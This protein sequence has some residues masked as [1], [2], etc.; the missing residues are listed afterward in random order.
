MATPKVLELAWS[1]EEEVVAPLAG[2]TDPRQTEAG[3]EAQTPWS[4]FW[5][6]VGSQRS[7]LPAGMAAGKSE[8]I[9]ARDQL[10]G[11]SRTTDY[12]RTSWN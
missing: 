12:S 4:R 3:T 6:L 10:L 7:T 8:N 1:E 2:Q 9:P 5:A 11:G